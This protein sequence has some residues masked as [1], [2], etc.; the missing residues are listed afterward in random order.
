MASK[1]PVE[2]LTVGDR[3]VRLTS[4]DKVWFPGPG[5]TKREVVQYYRTVSGPLLQVLFERPTNL[6]RYPDGVE[7][8]PFYGKRLPKGAPDYAETDLDLA[9]GW[10]AADERDHGLGELSY[11]PEYPKMAG[12]PMRVQ[13]SRARAS[14][15]QR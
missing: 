9:C 10:Y 12:E 1:A 15:D 4:P 3:E 13:P 7:G 8:E 5:I 14:G 6:K 2:L 11:P